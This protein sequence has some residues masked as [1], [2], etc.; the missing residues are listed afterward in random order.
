MN[1]AEV[2]SENKLK[3]PFIEQH[4]S[5]LKKREMCNPFLSTFPSF[6]LFSKEE[7]LAK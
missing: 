5:N 3:L 1:D 7:E 4:L 2:S 6:P